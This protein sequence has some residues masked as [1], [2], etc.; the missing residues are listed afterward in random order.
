MNT[1]E[2]IER[3]L[4]LVDLCWNILLKWRRVI[5]L[6]ILFAVIAVG[7]GLI[8]SKNTSPPIELEETTPENSESQKDSLVEKLTEEELTN[9]QLTERLMERKTELEA[10]LNESVLMNLDSYA[11]PTLELSYFVDSDYTYNIMETVKEDYTA[12]LVSAYRD[13]IANGS[14][15]ADII[16]IANLDI[17]QESFRELMAVSGS[18]G[19]DSD[20]LITIKVIYTNEKDLKSISAEIQRQLK[21]QETK[22]ND[23]VGK[24]TLKLVSENQSI[25]TDRTILD[26]QN[27]RVQLLSQWNAQ[28]ITLKNAISDVQQQLLDLN[29]AEKQLGLGDAKGEGTEEKAGAQPTL[30]TSGLIKYMLLGAILGV[31]IACAW[32]V[33]QVLLASRLQY[34]KELRDLYGLRV[35]GEISL[36]VKSRSIFSFVDRFLLNI[37]YRNQKQLTYEQQITLAISNIKIACTN[38]QIDTVFLSGSEIERMDANMLDR[39][40][41]E[42]KKAEIKVALGQNAFY[43]ATSLK[44][45]C[46]NGIVVLLEQAGISIYNEITKLIQLMKEQNVTILGAI[47]VKCEIDIK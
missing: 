28:I 14:F 32:S 46:E 8:K 39:I 35:F 2:A 45:M 5:A 44:D 18:G 15:N 12:A 37:R 13:H 21:V 47:G 34:V 42:L 4:S 7:A 41:T 17:T 1:N 20:N 26:R 36:P 3:E 6:G 33:L 38:D 9:V 30:G 29:T 31:F 24:H 43:D 23:M 40:Q 22:L 25:V 27:E 10:Y 19:Q 11:V 16:E